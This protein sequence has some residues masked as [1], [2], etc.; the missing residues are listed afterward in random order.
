MLRVK[1]VFL[2]STFLYLTLILT[3][4]LRLMQQMTLLHHF[5]TVELGSVAQ[6]KGSQI[7]IPALPHNFCR[8]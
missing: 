4:C 7:Q 1:V 3:T 5:D 6:I 2:L 8:Y